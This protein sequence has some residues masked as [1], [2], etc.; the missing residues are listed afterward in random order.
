ME[1]SNKLL[2]K[3]Y[4]MSL[5]LEEK[6]LILCKQ[7]N[8][9]LSLAE[10]CTGGAISARLTKVSGASNYYIG[11]I[12]SY[13]HF[14]KKELLGVENE[15]L[16]TYCSVSKETAEKMLNGLSL[17][18]KTDFALAVTGIAG[19]T[20]GSVDLPV[21]TVFIAIGGLHRETLHYHQIFE[22]NRYTI[23]ESVVDFSLNKLI[24]YLS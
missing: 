10:S 21:G 17:R 3:E 4:G 11:G 13:T 14:A 12:V 5:S 2:I 20:G 6:L 16:E 18:L 1:E 9:T 8:K 7:Q 23:I 15:I 24:D 22:G 19:P